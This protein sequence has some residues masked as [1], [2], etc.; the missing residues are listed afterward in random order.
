M[1]RPTKN[2]Q[3][4]TS[5]IMI[6]L[7]YKLQ[8]TQFKLNKYFCVLTTL[9]NGSKPSEK[10]RL[11]HGSHVEHARKNR[12]NESNYHRKL[13]LIKQAERGQVKLFKVL[14]LDTVP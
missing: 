3:P 2:I 12:K 9:T 13:E 6:S 5:N 8:Y 4:F 14:L 1:S 10:S 7:Q 11:I